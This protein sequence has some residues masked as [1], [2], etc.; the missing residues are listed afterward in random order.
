MRNVAILR[1]KT[2]DNGTFGR[3]YTDNEFTCHT[4]E[5]PWHKNK[6][7]ISCIPPGEYEA[8]YLEQSRSGKYHRVYHVTGVLS[9]VG[10]LIH[11]GNYAGDTSKGLQTH[12]KGCILVGKHTGF[13]GEQKAVLSSRTALSALTEALNNEAFK[14][15]I[16]DLTGG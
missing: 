10:I 9:R 3:L 16:I 12:S 6:T 13:L 2:G 1:T 11:A 15:T 14:L 5:L 7:N 4:L 8:Q